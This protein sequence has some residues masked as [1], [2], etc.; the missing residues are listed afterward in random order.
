MYSPSSQRPSKRKEWP[1]G[2]QPPVCFA[3]PW[4]LQS[5]PRAC[6]GGPRDLPQHPS[7]SGPSVLW[8]PFR[9]SAR[10]LTR[11]CKVKGGEW[12]ERNCSW[13]ALF[14]RRVC[15]GGGVIACSGRHT[16]TSTHTRVREAGL[17]P[18]HREL[19]GSESHYYTADNSELRVNCSLQITVT[20]TIITRW[21]V[22]GDVSELRKLSHNLF[23]G[24]QKQKWS[25]DFTS[26]FTSRKIFHH[27]SHS[28]VSGL[29]LV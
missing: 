19:I 22:G 9:S 13:S 27:C 10:L 21:G 29:S 24:N 28:S 25:R 14:C 2:T 8:A 15:V 16:H 11:L 7:S 4:P 6:P 23:L 18:A 5:S 12:L 20:V 3:L 26:Y 1:A 17:K